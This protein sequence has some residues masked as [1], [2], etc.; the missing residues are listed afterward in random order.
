MELVRAGGRITTGSD[1]P[2]V[3]YGLGL[4]A[5][6]ALLSEAGLANDQVLRLATADAALALGLERDLGTLESGKLADFIVLSGD[7]LSRITD[8]LRIEA[9]VK[10]GVWR[11]RRDLLAPP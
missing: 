9:T 4:H 10:D 7:P 5:E 8:T 1:S 3:P 11:D 6:L 2:S